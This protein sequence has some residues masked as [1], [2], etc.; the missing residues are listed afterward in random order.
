MLGMLQITVIGI[1]KPVDNYCLNLSIK[2]PIKH[3]RQQGKLFSIMLN[4]NNDVYSLSSIILDRAK[5][6][7][8]NDA[9]IHSH[10][11]SHTTHKCLLKQ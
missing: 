4:I 9:Q 7:V 1:T 11:A 8:H 10:S 6:K 2:P 5:I 3:V